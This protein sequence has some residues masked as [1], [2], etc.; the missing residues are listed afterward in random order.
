MPELNINSLMLLANRLR[1][2]DRS[3]LPGL[4]VQLNMAPVLRKHEIRGVGEGREPVTSS[5]LILLYPD[6]HN[7]VSTVMMQ[8]PTYDGVH[9]GQISFPGGRYEKSDGNLQ[10]TAIRETHEE[11]GIPPHKIE[12]INRLTDLYIPPS[13]YIVSPFIGLL[14]ETPV[15]KPDKKEVERLIT[16]PL[17]LFLGEKSIQKV[18]IRLSNGQTFHTPCYLINGDVIWGATAM[19]M[20]EFLALLEEFLSKK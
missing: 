19:I 3:N 15:F 2:M 1:N 20:A 10:L 5:V 18:P 9:S 8:R 12:I 17:K 13:N 14:Q 11:I 16:I 7:E 6:A 4:N